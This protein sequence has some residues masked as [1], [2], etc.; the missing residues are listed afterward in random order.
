MT[1]R[2]YRWPS[3][4]L[5]VQDKIAHL[6]E[7][8]VALGE[9]V[10]KLQEGGPYNVT[11]LSALADLYASFAGCLALFADQLPYKRGDRVRIVKAPKCEGGWAASKHF[12]V[13]GAIGTVA[14]VE[15]DYLMRDW[16]V[17]VCFDDESWIASADYPPDI[18][19]G[20]MT[21]VPPE[22]RHVYGLSPSY[23]EKIADLAK[24][25]KVA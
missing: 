23:V 10:T 12:L 24:E 5:D 16:H 15:V 19:K 2:Y 1:D 21:P 22:R 13:V 8:A 18:K 7:R 11:G 14:L 6:R 3:N 9:A 25:T 20:D 4:Q 17:S